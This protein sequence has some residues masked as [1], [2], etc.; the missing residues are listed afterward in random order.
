MRR[1]TGLVAAGTALVMTV[2]L[3]GAAVAAG[4]PSPGT[5]G[6]GTVTAAAEAAK[7]GKPG[8]GKGD[9]DWLAS[10]ARR[11]GV[12]VARLDAALRHV[13]EQLGANG[14]NVEDPAVVAG[15]A[16]DL[17]L[18]RQQATRLLAEVFDAAGSPGKG[19]PGKGGKPG[20][21]GEGKPGKPGDALAAFSAADLAKLLRVSQARAQAALD[22]VRTM[23]SGP[24]GSVDE[25]SARFAA[26]ARQSGV[27]PKQLADALFTLKMAAG[28]PPAQGP[29]K[30]A[31][32]A[33]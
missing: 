20:K 28:R 6:K 30:A 23:A 9:S 32:A 14:G 5:G 24:R 16:R 12:T 33:N 22:A 17:G 15:L 21:P 18:S 25:S 26:I 2:G 10:L 11:Y 4:T 8:K 7:A 1:R 31:A 29:G 19:K 3:T 13:K 27:T